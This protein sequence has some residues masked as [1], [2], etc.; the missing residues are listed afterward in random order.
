LTLMHLKKAFAIDANNAQAAYIT[1]R[2][3]QQGNV[4]DGEVG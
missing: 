1:L 4:N 3:H 2:L